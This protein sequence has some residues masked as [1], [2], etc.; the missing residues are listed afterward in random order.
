MKSFYKFNLLFF[1]VSLFFLNACSSKQEFNDIKVVKPPKWV[2]ENKSDGFSAIGISKGQLTEKDEDGEVETS[3]LSLSESKTR[4]EQNAISNLRLN[5]LVKLE[6]FF[7]DEA[8]VLYGNK[9][10]AIISLLNDTAKKLFTEDYLINISRQEEMWRS[11][12][13]D[14]LY[15]QMVAEK[16]LIASKLVEKLEKLQKKYSY[17]NELFNLILKIKNDVLYNNF[18]SGNSKVKELKKTILG[19]D[20]YDNKTA[21]STKK[22]G[23]VIISNVILTKEEKKQKDEKQKKAKKYF[24]VNGD[25]EVDEDEL[26]QRI[27][28][29]LDDDN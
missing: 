23:D 18:K 13:S 29:A 25:G 19:D 17:D 24:D 20:Y 12:D 14:M 2:T 7:T 15:V 10:N 16:Q 6:S 28:E 27:D 21:T 11:P 3:T 26:Y 9:R 1:V 5:L 8:S 22:H 4:A